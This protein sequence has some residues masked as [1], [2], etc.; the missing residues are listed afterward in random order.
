MTRSN[1]R[2]AGA[3]W[4]LFLTILSLQPVRLRATNRGTA[5]HFILHVL[6][7]GLAAAAPLLLSQNRPQASARA[8]G[9][10]CL[11]G[12]IEI[13]QGLIYRYKTEW[14]DFGFDGVGILLAFAL[15]LLWRFRKAGS[16]NP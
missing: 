13:A 1:V 11:A 7:F 15:V 16:E 8:L 14:W 6:L 5:A 10:L 3:V 2:R 12:A 4:I 9:I